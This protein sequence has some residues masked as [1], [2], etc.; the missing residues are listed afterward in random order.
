M[1]GFVR[2]AVLASGSGTNLQALLD[3]QGVGEMPSARVALVLS[4]RAGAKALE[5]AERAGVEAL[6]FDRVSLGRPRMEAGMLASLKERGIELLVMAGFLTILSPGFVKSF[7]NRIINVHPSLIPSFCGEG[8]HGLRVHESVLR[9][10]VKITGATV[11]LVD[12]IPDGG[13]ILAQEAVPVLDGDTPETLQRRV[14]EQV[15]WRLLPRTVERYCRHLILQGG[16]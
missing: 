14:M 16:V 9:R 2:V 5:R 8:F 12:E 15:E 4:D 13:P 11:H 7:E 1:S 10:G 3:A 6:A